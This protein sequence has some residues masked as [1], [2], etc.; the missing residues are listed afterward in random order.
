MDKETYINKL[1]EKLSSLTEEEKKE[2][3]EYYSDY[4]E[5]AENVEQAMKELGSPEELA[6]SIKEKIA[7]VPVKVDSSK[8][9]NN[10][11]E[12]NGHFEG[13]DSTGW[14]RVEKYN[15]GSEEIKNWDFSFGAAQI[16]VVP[17]EKGNEY[18]VEA[19]N[20]DFS[21]F[22]CEISKLGT[23]MISN[24]I[25]VNDVF[26]FG[27]GKSS[28]GKRNPP[29]ILIKTPSKVDLEKCKL[30]LG[31]GS[32][33]IRQ[34]EVNSGIYYVNVGAGQCLASRMNGGAFNVKCGMGKV[35]IEGSSR[36]ESSIGCGMGEV[37]FKLTGKMEDYSYNASV[38]LGD[39]SFNDAKKSG[40]GRVRSPA[41][42]GN[43]FSVKVGMGNVKILMTKE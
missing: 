40:F 36:G 27:K 20:I 29:R 14:D 15:F 7:G 3:V 10:E 39:F 26:K 30:S 21:V 17:N 37:S 16:V 38:G 12:Q 23:L 22:Q 42:L 24:K 32:L 4:L 43:N 8:T 1:N 31:A 18:S 2:A 35:E 28:S 11:T 19:R 41:K 34:V 33:E 9:E 5:E 25:L 6:Q 13:Y